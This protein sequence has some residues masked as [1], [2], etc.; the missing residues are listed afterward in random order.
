MTFSFLIRG[1][2]YTVHSKGVINTT[3]TSPYHPFPNIP[4]NEKDSY[5]NSKLCSLVQL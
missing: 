5:N 2:V 1:S 3:K 4:Y